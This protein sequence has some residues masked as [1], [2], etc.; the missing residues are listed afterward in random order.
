MS[1]VTVSSTIDSFLKSTTAT[2]AQSALRVVGT[3]PS[4][5]IPLG[6]IYGQTFSQFLTIGFSDAVTVSTLP[7]PSCSYSYVDSLDYFRSIM[8]G[9]KVEFVDVSYSG[10]AEILAVPADATA[11][12]SIKDLLLYNA[13]GDIEFSLSTNTCP[14]LTSV[15]ISIDTGALITNNIPGYCRQFTIYATQNN[16]SMVDNFFN[17]VSVQTLI[18]GGIINVSGAVPPTS[19]SR[20]ARASLTARG[21]TIIL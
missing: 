18:S 1:N 14:A 4:G 8:I 3:D 9:T 6:S 20:T 11:V 17:V 10:T 2:G 5:M 12:F 7:I 16:P 21:W 13:G 19:A 15:L